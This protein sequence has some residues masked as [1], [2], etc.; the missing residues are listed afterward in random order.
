MNREPPPQEAAEAARPLQDAPTES[1]LRLCEEPPDP[2]EFE[3][4][5]PVSQPVTGFT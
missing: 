5:E 4:P 2:N 1:F 3:V